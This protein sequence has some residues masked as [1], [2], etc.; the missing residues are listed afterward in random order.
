MR[1]ETTP[2]MLAQARQFV[3]EKPST[4]YVQRKLGIGY[5]HA[6]EIM[7]H[8]EA[9]GLVSPRRP[10]G[11]RVVMTINPADADLSHL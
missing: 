7:E 5:N 9:I 2:Q 6:C 8:F 10:D 1:P 3:L 4:S 11:T